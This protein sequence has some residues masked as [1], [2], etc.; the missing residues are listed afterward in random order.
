[1][2]GLLRKTTASWALFSVLGLLWLVFPDFLVKQALPLGILLAVL[3]NLW[4]LYEARTRPAVLGLFPLMAIGTLWTAPAL[5]YAL[6]VLRPDFSNLPMQV[7][8]ETYFRVAIPGVLALC[9]A[10]YMPLQRWFAPGRERAALVQALE[11][12]SEHR[13]FWWAILGLALLSSVPF[14][15]LPPALRF[16]VFLAHG[17]WYALS[18]LLV[19]APD[20]KHR[21]ALLFALFFLLLFEA[22]RSTMFGELVLVFLLGILYRITQKQWP[23]WQLLAGQLVLVLLVCYLISFKYDYR[24]LSKNLQSWPEKTAL[25]ARLAAHRLF[26]P[27]EPEVADILV[28]RLG[29]GANMSLALKQVPANQPF[30]QGETIWTAVKSALVPRLLQPDKPVAGGAENV[31]RFM[32]IDHLNYS[33]NLGVVGE[34]YVNFGADWRFVLFL[35]VYVLFFRVLYEGSLY[36]L[37]EMPEWVFFLPL[38]FFTVVSME[39]DVLTILNHVVKSLALVVVVYWVVRFWRYRRIIRRI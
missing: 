7:S 10:C 29:Q 16:P 5:Q 20:L 39:K 25:F 38:V 30:V 15:Y 1:M 18:V 11:R 31:R 2:S 23:L 14:P 34:A 3:A 27:W 6:E 33:I 35:V 19:C 13:F 4:F 9:W 28:A 26:H 32:G 36:M 22:I 21:K 37:G 12:F 24:F 8:A 17:C